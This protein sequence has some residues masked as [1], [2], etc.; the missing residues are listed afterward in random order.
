MYFFLTQTLSNELEASAFSNLLRLFILISS[1]CMCGSLIA[2]SLK[3]LVIKGSLS[4]FF[5]ERVL[6]ARH[7]KLI[8]ASGSTPL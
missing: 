5:M 2:F 6:D 4:V 3:L 1:V 8:H 7:Q